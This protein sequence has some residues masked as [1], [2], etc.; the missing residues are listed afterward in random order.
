M[1]DKI[2]SQLIVVVPQNLLIQLGTR[3]CLWQTLLKLQFQLVAAKAWAYMVDRLA[4]QPVPKGPMILG[5]AK[6]DNC[7]A[8]DLEDFMASYTDQVRQEG[9]HDELNA[10]G[11]TMMQPKVVKLWTNLFKDNRK[12]NIAT[13]LHH[14]E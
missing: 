6:V 2:I 14:F 8:T 5:S 4:I 10:K 9:E 3:S 7:N 1:L 12:A 13:L 11:A